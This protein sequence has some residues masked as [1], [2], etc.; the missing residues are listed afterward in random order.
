MPK[1]RSYDIIGIGFFSSVKMSGNFKYETHICRHSGC[2]IDRT[3]TPKN[4]STGVSVVYKLPTDSIIL[5]T[6]VLRFDVKK[7][8]DLTIIRQAAVG[9]YSHATK[10]V[11]LDQALKHNIGLSGIILDS[12]VSAKYDKIDEAEANW[13][14][15][16]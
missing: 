12:S 13:S 11:T 9:D 2:T 3:H 15:N 1:V 4:T 7:N 14:G 5:L 8:T 6:S 10:T 16:W